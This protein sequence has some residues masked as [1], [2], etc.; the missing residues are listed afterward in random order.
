MAW[1]SLSGSELYERGLEQAR[2]LGVRI[3][4]AQVLGVGGFDTFTV[5]TTEGGSSA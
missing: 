5:K 3:L 2:H 1:S 4:E